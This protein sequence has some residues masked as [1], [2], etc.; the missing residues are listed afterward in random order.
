MDPRKRTPLVLQ[1][2]VLS[3]LLLL[4]SS[5]WA[6][7]FSQESFSG[8]TYWLYVPSSYQAGT[9]MPLIMMLHGCTQ[10]GDGFATSTGMNAIAETE[11]FLVVYPTQPS[12]AN[13]SQCWNW[14]ETVHQSRGSGEPA[15]L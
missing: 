13:S 7:T 10:S 1:L 15:L 11:G 6:G 12:S 8:R 2:A 5:L 4:P 14:F 3:V 9:D